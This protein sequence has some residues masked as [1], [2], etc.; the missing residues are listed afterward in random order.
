MKQATFRFYAALNDLL[1]RRHR[2]RSFA[3]AFKGV[4]SVKDAIEALGIPH[5]EVDLVLVNDCSVAFDHRINDSDRVA[6]Y[7]VFESLDIGCLVRLRPTPLRRV[8]F[9]LDVHLGKLARMLR[10]LGFDCLYRNDFEDAQ[11][12]SI[13]TAQRRIILTKDRGILKQKAVT[14]GYCLRSAAPEQQA[15]EVLRR[16]DLHREAA[17]WTRCINCNGSIEP[18]DKQSVRERLPAKT[19]RYYEDFFRCRQ[20]RQIYWHGSHMAKM[21]ARIQRLLA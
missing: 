10:M 9:I 17:P 4:P 20:C 6:V 15:R 16:F 2:K 14:H 21:A 13:A 3:Y 18:V 5:T 19:R 12:V 8:R 1:P 7:P 11:I